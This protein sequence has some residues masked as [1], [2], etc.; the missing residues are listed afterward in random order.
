MLLVD[1]VI[2]HHFNGIER[3][4]GV[5]ILDEYVTGKLMLMNTHAT[6]IKVNVN[7]EK[8]G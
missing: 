2:I 1:F 8:R 7:V 3:A 4:L 5:A 6:V